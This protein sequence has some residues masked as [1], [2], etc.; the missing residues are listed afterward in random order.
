MEK[1]NIDILAFTGHKSLLGPMGIGGFVLNWEGDFKPFKAGGTG[2]D[3]KIEYQPDYLPNKLETGTPNVPGIVGLKEGIDFINR[4]GIN[5]IIKKEKML[6]DYAL[7]ELVNI[8][9]IDI[10]GPR[11]SEEIANVISFNIKGKS[12]EE[13]AYHLDQDYGVMVRIGLHCAPTA[14]EILGTK[15]IGAIRISIGYFNEKEDID[16]LVKGLKEII[17]KI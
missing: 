8:D 12:S 3:S 16:V 7:N 6:L 11:N 9:G 14:H 13:I 2:G 10:Y 15:D 17:E 5:E 4:I 1:D